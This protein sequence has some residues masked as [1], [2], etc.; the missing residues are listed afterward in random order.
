M[1]HGLTCVSEAGITGCDGARDVTHIAGKLGKFLRDPKGATAIEYALIASIMGVMIVV[2]VLSD[3]PS[4]VA[5]HYTKIQVSSTVSID[6]VQRLLPIARNF[7]RRCVRSTSPET[8][9]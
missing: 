6:L 3:T 1:I 5:S 4:G 8:L 9:R 7:S 2:P